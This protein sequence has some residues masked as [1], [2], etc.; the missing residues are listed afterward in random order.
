MNPLLDLPWWALVLALIGVLALG[1]LVLNLFSS[2]G[3]RPD[4]VVQIG[5]CSVDSVD[6]L[7]ALSGVI[8]APLH[9]GGTARLLNNGDEFLPAM[10]EAIRGAEASVNFTTYIWQDGEVSDAF[11][12]AL[13]ERARAGVDV[14]VLI[15]GFGGLRA[16]RDRIDAFREAGG[17]W[18][19]FHAPRFGTLTRMH[20]RTHRRALVVDGL[21]GFT[22]G[23]AVMDKWLGD[24]QGPDHW[25]DCMVEVRGRLAL[26]LQSAFTQ[27][28]TQTTGE[29]LSGESFYPLHAHEAER[30]GEGEAISRHINVISSP[31]SVAHPMRHVFW[32]SIACALERVYITN[33]YFVPDDILVAV[34]KERARAGVD[35]RV[36]VPDPKPER[37]ER[38][39]TR[40]GTRT[41][42]STS[43]TSKPSRM[44]AGD[45]VGD[46]RGLIER[47]DYVQ[48]LGVDCIW[49]LPF[50]PSPLRDDGYD[51]AD[52]YGIHPQLRE[53]RGLPAL[54]RRGPPARPAG[55][56][57]PGAQPHLQ[58]SAPLVPARPPGARRGRPSATSTSGATTTTPTRTPASS[59]PTPSPS[60][61]TWDPVAQ[62]YYW[63]RFFSHQPDLNW[64]NPE[65]KEDDVPGD[66]VLAG[67]RPRR[68]PRR[69]RALPHR[70]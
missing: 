25:R 39:A 50:Y 36:L 60:N 13:T 33:P 44:R 1:T 61:W 46:F 9:R 41:P 42:Y 30:D 62:Q 65:V 21:I 31:S 37:P 23:A 26:S 2:L 12:H 48:D 68:V 32:L 69:R 49:L 40:C 19:R 59:S 54:P 8:N 70:A 3:D 14:R 52:Y 57:R 43:C 16:P 53:P 63:H 28:W 22:G 35:I 10:L 15:D 47:L 11:F 45:G 34:L 67:P 4:E 66:G 27:L 55:D 56:R 64:D 7:L 24:A 17:T 20:K 6:F 51:I 58:R 38:R 18:E 29:V 5:S